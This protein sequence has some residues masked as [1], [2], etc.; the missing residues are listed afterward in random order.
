[1][2]PFKWYLYNYIINHANTSTIVFWGSQTSPHCTSLKP[3]FEHWAGMRAAAL[4]TAVQWHGA[5]AAR[6]LA[7]PRH[8]WFMTTIYTIH[9]QYAAW[10]SASLLQLLAKL[11][12]MRKTSC[13]FVAL[14]LAQ[15]KVRWCSLA[16]KFGPV[17]GW[18]YLKFYSIKSRHFFARISI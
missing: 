14:L 15:Q 17:L 16:L 9:Q 18:V 4:R 8:R 11:R 1:M 5:A 2:Q 13:C 12:D 7:C 6:C 10:K 3:L